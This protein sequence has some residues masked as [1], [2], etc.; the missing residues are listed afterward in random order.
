MTPLCIDIYKYIYIIQNMDKQYTPQDSV[1]VLKALADEVRLD[2]V[3]HLAASEGQTAPCGDV[4][5]P[6]S[7]ALHLTQPTMS[8]HLTV[9]VRAGV[10]EE[11]KNGKNK[12][13]RLNTSYLR[14]IGIDPKKL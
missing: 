2:I 8:H 5:G 11:Q 7:K 10:L 13:Y 4:V 12:S 3:R 1:R 6:C 14:G 9:L